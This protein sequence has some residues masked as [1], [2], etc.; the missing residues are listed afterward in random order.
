MNIG[1]LVLV[2]ALDLG[3]AGVNRQ[4]EVGGGGLIGVHM[5]GR[6]HLNVFVFTVLAL[7]DVDPAACNAGQ[8]RKAG[9]QS[10]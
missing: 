1:R 10:E 5:E 4:S 6:I 7:V 9:Y 2:V 3:G 8:E